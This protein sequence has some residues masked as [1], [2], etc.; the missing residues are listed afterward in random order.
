VA[1]L[2]FAAI[3]TIGQDRVPN[4]QGYLKKVGTITKEYV[5][6][7]SVIGFNYTTNIILYY[8]APLRTTVSFRTLAWSYRRDVVTFK[9][10]DDEQQ[11]LERAAGIL[12]STAVQAPMDKYRTPAGIAPA[13]PIPMTAAQKPKAKK[14]KPVAI[15]ID[16]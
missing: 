6:R 7:C 4:L 11:Q 3:R 8:Q 12:K 1:E 10:K 14:S 2:W 16:D 15:V 13:L 5:K 9:L